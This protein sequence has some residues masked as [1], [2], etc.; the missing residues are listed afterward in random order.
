M[1]VPSFVHRESLGTLSSVPDSPFSG[2]S[3]ESWRDLIALPGTEQVDSS[4]GPGYWLLLQI[5]QP[6]QLQRIIPLPPRIEAA[7]QRA[8]SGYSVPL[9]LQRRTGAGSFVWSSA[10]EDDIAISRD[11]QMF[12]L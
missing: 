10:V 11:L 1:A 5:H 7:L 3:G 12:F 9:E 8:H 4:H 6:H 2:G